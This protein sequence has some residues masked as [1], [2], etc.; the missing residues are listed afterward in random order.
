MKFQISRRGF[1]PILVATALCGL[2]QCGGGDGGA[3]ATPTRPSPTV[4]AL[5]LVPATD[6]MKVGA[7]VELA[8]QASWSDGS[9]GP[10]TTATW[11]SSNRA[12]AEVAGGRVTAV[13]P[14]ETVIAAECQHGRASATVRVVP[15]YHGSWSGTYRMV[16]CMATGDL[17]REDACDLLDTPAI[18]GMSLRLNQSRAEVSGTLTLGML[19]GDVQGAIAAPGH[20]DLHGAIRYQENGVTISIDLRDWQT[21][22]SGT[23]MTGAFTQSWTATGAS[24]SMI[25][26][27]ELQDVVRTS[28]TLRPIPAAAVPVGRTP[29]QRAVS[30][31][32]KR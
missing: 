28:E 15:D 9:I 10:V 5:A 22:A 29:I 8:V 18:A 7:T 19:S 23:R 12:V 27:C 32:L 3:Q 13:G 17:A 16:S 4:V 1:A 21:L 26:A 20:L 14:G 2:S 6:M 11:S 30:V 31:L 24:G 25:V